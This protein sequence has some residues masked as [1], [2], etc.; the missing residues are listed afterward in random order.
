MGKKLVIISLL[1]F[2]AFYVAAQQTLNLQG[3]WT[4]T[5]KDNKCDINLPGTLDM[6]GI[7]IPTTLAP[8]LDKQVLRHLTR[9]VS[10]I[11]TADYER[12]IEIPVEMA[13]KPLVIKFERVLWRSRLFIDGVEHGSS[14]ESLTTPH[15][16]RFE[17][18]LQA[19]THVLRVS[20]DNTK[21]YDMSY[22]DMAHAY[23]NETQTMWNG[24]LGEM[25]VT[26]LP[27][28]SLEQLQI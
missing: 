14:C 12:T 21:Q 5:I 10:F 24:I 6:A 19:G 2:W 7:G 16:Y 20:V 11:G 9:R 15:I 25:S 13:G 18:G 27:A 3:D 1:L 22:E 8:S 28:V 23:T 26:A 4:V 17:N